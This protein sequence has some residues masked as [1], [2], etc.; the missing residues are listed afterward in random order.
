MRRYL[1]IIIFSDL[2]LIFF[3]LTAFVILYAFKGKTNKIIETGSPLV[4]LQKPVLD[5]EQLV[6]GKIVEVQKEALVI[7]YKGKQQ[8]V[9][10]AVPAVIMIRNYN[11]QALAY[12]EKISNIEDIEKKSYIFRVGE[13][14]TASSLE[15]SDGQN[16]KVFARNFV[17]MRNF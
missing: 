11:D 5:N 17:V 1:K 12:S 16:D 9:Y 13:E 15:F 14:V 4:K 8:K 3:I 10:I 6:I 7:E 2:I